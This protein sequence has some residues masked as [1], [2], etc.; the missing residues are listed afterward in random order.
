MKIAVTDI[1]RAF[2]RQTRAYAEYRVFSSLARLSDVVQDATVS[3][4]PPTVTE[5]SV[6]CDVSV[7]VQQ[8]TQVRVTARGRHA[9]D[10]INRAAERINNALRRHVDIAV[11]P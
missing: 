10:A 11:T 9:Y 1:G 8:G 6:V 3:L 7:T 5:P 2:G 4:T